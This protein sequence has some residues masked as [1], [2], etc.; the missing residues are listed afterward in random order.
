MSNDIYNDL[1]KGNKVPKKLYNKIT[2]NELKKVAIKKEFK[3]P[4]T[5]LK[6]WNLLNTQTP[7]IDKI[8]LSLSKLKNDKKYI[9]IIYND[10]TY[11][12]VKNKH[13]KFAVLPSDTRVYKAL[14]KTHN[15]ERYYKNNKKSFPSFYGTNESAADYNKAY[16][17]D[18]RGVVKQFKTTRPAKMF[19]LNDINNLI[20]LANLFSETAGVHGLLKRSHKEAVRE[21]MMVT[22]LGTHCLEQKKYRKEIEDILD[23]DYEDYRYNV[24]L[25]K[26]VDD[27]NLKRLSL[28][29]VDLNFSKNLCIVLKQYGCDGYIAQDIPTCFGEY[30]PVFHEEMMFC[31]NSE[32]MVPV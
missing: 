25:A 30:L 32:I 20:Q 8:L 23:L 10:Q 14:P 26:Q 17:P 16:F 11:P 6:T 18:G 31:F 13:I 3:I 28:Y 5:K 22:G 4:N 24:N 2:F 7:K 12:V 19:I 15:V 1:L 9:E 29:S 27:E 21:L